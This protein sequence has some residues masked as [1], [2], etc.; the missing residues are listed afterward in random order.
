MN[1]ILFPLLAIVTAALALFSFM[2]LSVVGLIGVGLVG[3]F[4][5]VDRLTGGRF[6][7]RVQQKADSNGSQG[8]NA[9]RGKENSDGINHVWNDGRGPIIDM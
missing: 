6:S 9:T 4:R 8:S 2:A 1:R 5:S 3:L 7:A